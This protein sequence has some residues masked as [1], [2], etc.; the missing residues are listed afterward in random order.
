MNVAVCAISGPHVSAMISSVSARVAISMPL[1][2]KMSSGRRAGSSRGRSCVSV[3][4]P[5]RPR[6]R[7]ADASPVRTDLTPSVG[8]ANSTTSV[9]ASSSR[10]GSAGPTAVIPRAN[11]WSWRQCGWRWCALKCATNGAL[12]AHSR[13]ACAESARCCGRQHVP[14]AGARHAR[15]RGSSRSCPRRGRR[16]GARAWASARPSAAASRRGRGSRRPTCA[17]VAGGGYLRRAPMRRTGR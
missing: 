14:P 16:R 3:S 10:V 5:I 2:T 8:I 17:Q 7:S 4:L 11:A 1:F 6:Q 15:P 9:A 13:T 12:R